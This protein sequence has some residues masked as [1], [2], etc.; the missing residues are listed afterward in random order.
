MGKLIFQK[1]LKS[2]D[3]S[4]Y[5]KRFEFREKHNII[6]LDSKLRSFLGEKYRFK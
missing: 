6:N 1:C 4:E 3:Q 5:Q 2:E